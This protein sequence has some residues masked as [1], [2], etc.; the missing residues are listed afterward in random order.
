MQER[1][2]QVG[3]PVRLQL[4]TEIRRH[5]QDEVEGPEHGR[6]A[7][8]ANDGDA[9]DFRTYLSPDFKAG[10]EMDSGTWHKGQGR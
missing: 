5:Q 8:E 6:R 7:V 4:R 9:E 1:D 10:D 3:I 2:S